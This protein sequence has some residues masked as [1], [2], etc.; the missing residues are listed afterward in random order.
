MGT[1]ASDFCP[2]KLCRRS[3]SRSIPRSRSKLEHEFGVS[4]AGEEAK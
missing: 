3:M 1:Q 2:Y 4:G